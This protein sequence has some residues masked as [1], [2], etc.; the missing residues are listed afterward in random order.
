MTDNASTETS[1]QPHVLPRGIRFA[2]VACGIKASGKR[3]VSMIVTD[4]PAVIAGVY[5]T[6]QIVAAPVVL[7][8]SKTPTASGRVVL[9]N[10]G[11]ANA[12][13]GEEGMQNAQTMCQQAADLV[14]CDPSD[15]MVMSTGVIGHPLPM[16][17][18][19]SGIQSA[20]DNLSDDEE[21]YL[22]SADAICTTD[23]FRKTASSTVTIDGHDYQITAMCKGAG[24]IAPNM[25]TML[26]VITTDAPIGPDAAHASLKSIADSTFNRVSVDGHTST[27]DTVML[28]ATGLTD[29]KGASELSSDGLALWQE[30]ASQVA[31][32]LA[33]L[34]VADGEGAARFFEVRVSGAASDS[35]ALQI[36]KSVAAS[37]LV[38]TAITGGDPN[39]GRIVSAA[40]YAGPKITPDRTTL[41]I[42]GVTVFE[43]GTPQKIDAAKLS[44]AMKANSE[45]LA[46]LRVG[47]GPGKA[48]FW[49]SDLTE[50]YV[51]FNSLYTT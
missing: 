21:A 45:V 18:V 39:W 1:D 17:K 12:C 50:A 30:A 24:M 42:D 14:G 3:D 41:V 22:A 6:N 16:E 23:Q 13:T 20:F 19:Q 40:G 31:L 36:A 11:N 46:D 8:R 4:R 44:A 10:S 48:S 7:T 9:T 26:G 34:L 38:K 28:V 43:N 5:T 33:K 2:G 32:R 47:D 25:A 49:A 37:P 29:S 27:N 51:R 35:D 15:V